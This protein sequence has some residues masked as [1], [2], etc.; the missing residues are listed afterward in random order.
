MGAACILMGN[1][2]PDGSSIATIDDARI[3]QLCKIGTQVAES[4]HAAFPF[5][6]FRI[7][8]GTWREELRRLNGVSAAIDSWRCYPYR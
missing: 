2:E 5:G 8:V 4:F 1:R 7:E 3:R 6:A